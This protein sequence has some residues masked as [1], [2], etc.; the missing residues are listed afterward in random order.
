MRSS[1]AAIATLALVVGACNGRQKDA[2]AGDTITPG[3]PVA[4]AGAAGATGASDS[5]AGR[6][7]ATAPMRDAK[8]RDL[9]TVTLTETG[10]GIAVAGTLR[11]LPPGTHAIHV[12]TTGKC[13]PPFE[14]AGGH[15]N[16]TNRQH[17]AQNPQG[18]HLGDMPNITV[19]ADSSAT[20]RVT[21][22]GGTLRGTDALMDGDGATV[23][24]H[25]GADDYRSNPAG[26]AGARVACGVVTGA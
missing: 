4:A 19:G 23:M 11:G 2:A 3:A 9:G 20:V 8:G 22:S 25:A 21:T 13:E 24:V 16:P 12:H 18:P 10:Q 15:W 1:L 14:S 6:A 26:N 17:G 7:T 5:A